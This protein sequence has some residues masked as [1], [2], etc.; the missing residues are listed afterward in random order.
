MQDKRSCSSFWNHDFSP[1]SKTHIGGFSLHCSPKPCPWSDDLSCLGPSLSIPE[2]NSVHIQ[3]MPLIH[4]TMPTRISVG[5][6]PP[7]C[8][9]YFLLLQASADAT[10]TAAHHLLCH[11]GDLVV[12]VHATLFPSTVPLPCPHGLSPQHLLCQPSC[13]VQLYPHHVNPHC[14]SSCHC[15]GQAKKSEDLV[16]H[17]GSWKKGA[18]H[19]KNGEYHN[20]GI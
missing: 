16:R 4:A 19:L 13:H 12:S 6:N 1:L 3:R 5:T 10:A 8:K 7:L 14:Y 2:A 15:G 18:F 11:P 20:A 17:L 9:Q